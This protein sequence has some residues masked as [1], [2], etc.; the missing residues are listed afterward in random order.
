M[1][2]CIFYAFSDGGTCFWKREKCYTNEH[3][4]IHWEKILKTKQQKRIYDQENAK[5]E[6]FH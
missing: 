1:L 2:V 6:V 5:N 3:Y 4:F